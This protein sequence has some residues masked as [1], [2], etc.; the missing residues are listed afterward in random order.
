MD[1]N[2]YLSYLDD[3]T[4]KERSIFLYRLILKLSCEETAKRLKLPIKKVQDI[5][6]TFKYE[7]DLLPLRTN[8]FEAF[9]V[10]V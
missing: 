4:H 6:N 8:I 2:F 7:I 9:E 1:K 10:F 5:T 3:L